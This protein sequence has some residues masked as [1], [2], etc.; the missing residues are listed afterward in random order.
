MFIVATAAAAA[1]MLWTNMRW[2]S[3]KCMRIHLAHILMLLLML[4]LCGHYHFV[5]IT[6]G[7][8][9][10]MRTTNRWRPMNEMRSE[11]KRINDK[12][13]YTATSDAMLLL[14]HC[15]DYAAMF[16]NLCDYCCDDCAGAFVRP[17]LD[18][19]DGTRTTAHRLEHNRFVCEYKSKYGNRPK[20]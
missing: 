5:F 17:R 15:A 19:D 2:Q 3:A 14:T 16:G 6:A 7:M 11:E 20:P 4:V 18:A 8:L 13:Q 12:S 1:M 9:Q 10:R